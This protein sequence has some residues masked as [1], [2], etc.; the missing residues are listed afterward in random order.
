MTGALDLRENK[1]KP[2]RVQFRSRILQ[3]NM[4]QQQPNQDACGLSAF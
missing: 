2:I 1:T 3:N 4:L